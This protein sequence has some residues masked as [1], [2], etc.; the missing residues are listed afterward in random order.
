MRREE[1]RLKRDGAI[2]KKA[3]WMESESC[4]CS[5]ELSGSAHGPRSWPVSSSESLV[6]SR[7]NGVTVQP[8]SQPVNQGLL[9][10]ASKN[11]GTESLAESRV[12][13]TL[14]MVHMWV[15]ESRGKRVPRGR[16]DVQ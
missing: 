8:K 4:K 2:F 9:V 7:G 15:C 11:L 13:Q 6:P 10:S 12:L 1:R 3:I 16:L 14:D 5:Q